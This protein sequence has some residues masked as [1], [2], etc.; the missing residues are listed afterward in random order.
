MLSDVMSGG[1]AIV[2][3]VQSWFFLLKKIGFAPWPDT[4]LNQKLMYYWQEIFLL[5]LTSDT[6]TEA[7]LNDTIALFVG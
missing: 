6:E 3:D 1:L 2:L 4:M 5:T 7:I